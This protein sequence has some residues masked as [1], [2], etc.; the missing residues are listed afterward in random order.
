[1]KLSKGWASGSNRY[2]YVIQISSHDYIQLSASNPMQF[3]LLLPDSSL[4]RFPRISF[5][6]LSLEQAPFYQ[7]FLSQT[8]GKADV[9]EDDRA[10][11]SWLESPSNKVLLASYVAG[12]RAAVLSAQVGEKLGELSSICKDEKGDAVK[13]AVSS[14]SAEDRAVLLEALQDMQ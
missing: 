1:M 4:H 11:V 14:M 3:F 7:Y 9:W 5:S 8:T 10:V 12:K 2:V 13:Q 6:S